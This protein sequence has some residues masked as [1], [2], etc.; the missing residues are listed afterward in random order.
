MTSYNLLIFLVINCGA[1]PAIANG[2][3]SG[4]DYSYDAKVTYSCNAANFKLSGSQERTCQADGTWSGTQP[5][6]LGE[7]WGWYVSLD[8]PSRSTFAYVTSISTKLMQAIYFGN[9]VCFSITT[10]NMIPDAAPR[11]TDNFWWLA[12]VWLGPQ[13]PFLS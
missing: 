10:S 2:Q 7:Y 4:S 3:I 9:G 6:C 13:K 12:Q 1:P 11:T 5:A 8:D